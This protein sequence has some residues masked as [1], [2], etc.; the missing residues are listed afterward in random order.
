M[1][2]RFQRR[3]KIAPGLNLNISKSGVGVSAGIKGATVSAGKRGLYGNLGLP[4][5]GLSYRSK[6]NKEES[7]RQPSPAAHLRSYLEAGNEL[8]VRISV[9]SDGDVTILGMNGE[10]FSDN[11]LSV[12]RKYLGDTIRDALASHCEVMNSNLEELKNIHKG[13]L[14]ASNHS[15]YEPRPFNSPRPAKSKPLSYGLWG[16][17]WPPQKRRIT[18]LNQ[19]L[20]KEHTEALKRWNSEKKKHFELEEKRK[21]LETEDIFESQNALAAVLEYYLA[22]IDWPVETLID[23]DF[24]D[25]S[26]TVAIDIDLPTEDQFPDIEYKVPGRQLKITRSRINTTRRRGM[27]RDYAHGAALRIAGLIFNHLPPVNTCVISA[28]TQS[29]E[30]DVYLYS[31]IVRR[32]EWEKLNFGLWNESEPVTLFDHFTFTRNMTKT[33]I[34]KP[35]T[36]LNLDSLN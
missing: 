11:E 34:F 35:V 17:I 9:E 33:G 8:A 3:I 12:I 30:G 10:A 19:L 26:S 27:Y 24:G 23:F 5:T 2:F 6:L 16:F 1:S 14:P 20:E 29:D 22:D 18:E 28:Y 21:K 4:G 7:R 13:T 36:P 25:D 32:D 15:N 31:V